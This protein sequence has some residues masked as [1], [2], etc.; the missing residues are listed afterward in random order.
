MVTRWKLY[1]PV[2]D[3]EY[4]FPKNPSQMGS[5]HRPRNITART[6]TAVDGQALVTEGNAPPHQWFF[7]GSVRYAADYEA[8]REWTRRPNRVQITDHFG[9]SFYVAL[10]EFKV[11]PKKWI[12]YYWAHAYDI[13]ALILTIPTA[14]TVGV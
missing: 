13:P 4:T 11:E 9:R 5:V 12:N 2:L 7:K 14:P 6:T 1:D 3:E 8:L 10:L